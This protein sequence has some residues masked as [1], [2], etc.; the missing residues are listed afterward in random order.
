MNF[1]TNII[2]LDEMPYR[3]IADWRFSKDAKTCYINVAD[4]GDEDYHNAL[5]LHETSEIMALLRRFS[6]H[7]AVKIVDTFDKRFEKN[8]K[9]DFETD[10][11]DDPRAPYHIE[12]GFATGIERTYLAS[13]GRNWK[14][15][16]DKISA[17]L[18]KYK[19]Q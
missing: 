2:P 15:Y 4:L 10:P 1:V 16:E 9:D 5:I 3:T 13:A 18:R 6:P 7:E 8:R 11:G 12:H 17:M 19:K 14:K